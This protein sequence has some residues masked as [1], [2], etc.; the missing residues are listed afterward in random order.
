MLISWPNRLTLA[1]L[2]L[3]GPFVVALL[4]LQEP[5]FSQI[6]RYAAVFVFFLMAITDGLDGYL[7]R[8]LKQESALGRFLDPLADKLLILST[9]V[10][11][12]HEGTHVPGA[13]LPATV[14][15][16]AVAKDLVVVLG[17]C[18]I[19][20]TTSKIFISP[21]WAGKWCTL[22][23]L[24]M[25]IAVLISPD[26]PGSLSYY[27]PRVFWWFASVLAVAAIISY[28]RIGHRFIARH[29]R[30]VAPP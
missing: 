26:L 21:S 9:V 6:A 5:R 16:I 20:F 15:V 27:F 19:Y 11:L 28:Y 2:V 29:E 10:L 12:A 1:R 14:A 22:A 4:N 18:I 7:A 3:I 25:V 24:C 8:R 17:F 23:Q 30:E 13:R